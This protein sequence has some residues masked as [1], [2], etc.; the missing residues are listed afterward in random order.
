MLVVDVLPSVSSKYGTTGKKSFM[1]LTA[2]WAVR[3]RKYPGKT[4]A[5]NAQNSER[6]A[7]RIGCDTQAVKNWR[8]VQ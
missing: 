5:G 6:A 2:R 8:D 7:K 4:R 3:R 1:G